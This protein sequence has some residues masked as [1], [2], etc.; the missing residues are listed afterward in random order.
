MGAIALK[1]VTLGYGRRPAV[2]G[3]SGVFAQGCATA[4]IGPNG[5]GKSTLLKAL[6]GLQPPLSGTIDLGGLP[7]RR[8]AYLPQD[9]GVAR[10]FPI[11]L[12]DFAALGFERR[13]G[14]FGGL[15][16]GERAEL[17]AALDAVGLHGLEQRG[18]DALSGGQFQRALFAR[19]MAE[20]APV[21]LLDE[22]FAAQDGQTTADLLKVIRRWANEGRTLIIVLHDLALARTLSQET[23]VLARRC[24]AWGPT[25]TVLTPDHLRRAQEACGR[26]P[27]EDA[28]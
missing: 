21:I 28:A 7:R 25:E 19:V 5:S 1:D 20:D 12:A 11:T 9:P 4:V 18:V 13:L 24:V 26:W 3:L 17:A 16:G 2:S 14:L 22:P 6:A 23:L 8:I 10:G 27:E 15:G